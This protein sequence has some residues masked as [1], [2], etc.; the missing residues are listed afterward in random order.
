MSSTTT[1]PAIA[2]SENCYEPQPDGS[3]FSTSWPGEQFSLDTTPFFTQQEIQFFQEA[4]DF[5]NLEGIL[6]FPEVM[7]DD[8]VMADTE[9]KE[10]DQHQ[11]P[12]TPEAS[13]AEAASSHSEA[14]TVRHVSFDDVPEG[15]SQFTRAFL[16]THACTLS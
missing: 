14:N 16:Y 3:Q 11:A 13:Q 5:L 15:E 1:C 12:P 9:L 10:V 7:D 6:P 4:K 8:V 2:P